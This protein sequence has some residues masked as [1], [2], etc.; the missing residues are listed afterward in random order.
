MARKQVDEAA[1]IYQQVLEVT[2]PSASNT[3]PS[4]AAQLLRD[5][6]TALLK[7]GKIYQLSSDP[8]IRSHLVALYDMLHQQNLLW[9]IE[10]YEMVDIA[11]VAEVGQDLQAV[12][13]K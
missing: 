8:T 12:E 2:A 13:V 9:T 7:L 1:A 10:P 5:Q 3:N 6:E 4:I 11:H